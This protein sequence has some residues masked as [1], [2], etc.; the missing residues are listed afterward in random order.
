M[1]LTTEQRFESSY[2]PEPNSGCWLW[3][4]ASNGLYGNFKVGRRPDRTTVGAHRFSYVIHKGPIPDGL[5]IDHK[6]N[7]KLC[8]NPDHLQAVTHKRNQE[9]KS[10]RMLF[11][12]NGHLRDDLYVDNVG[13]KHCRYCRRRADKRRW[14]TGQ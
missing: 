11:C 3:L 4:G 1:I 10:E 14:R 6:C 9:F 8:V 5:E 13:K 7:N 2:I 12:K